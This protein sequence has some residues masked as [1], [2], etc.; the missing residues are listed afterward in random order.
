MSLIWQLDSTAARSVIQLGTADDEGAVG[1]IREP[2]LD[3]IA[4]VV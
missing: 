3:L 1:W 4:V 2:D